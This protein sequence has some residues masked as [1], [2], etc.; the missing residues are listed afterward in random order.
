MALSDEAYDLPL[1][2]MAAC[3]GGTFTDAKTATDLVRIFS[4]I[5]ETIEESTVPF[6][7]DVK[8]IVEP[9]VTVVPGS[10]SG[11][12]TVTSLPD[13]TTQILWTNIDG[14]S[15]LSSSDPVKQF[16]YRA[17][18]SRGGQN[19]PVSVD[20]SQVSFTDKNG[21]IRDFI[22]T[23]IV[24]ANVNGSPNAVCKDASKDIDCTTDP[25][26]ACF[27][28]A[29]V[30]GGST[31]YVCTAGT[32]NSELEGFRL[33]PDDPACFGPGGH[34]VILDVN[35]TNGLDAQCTAK[36]FVRDPTG[37]GPPTPQTSPPTRSPTTPA[38]NVSPSAPTPPPTEPTDSFDAPALVP[39]VLPI[40]PAIAPAIAPFVNNV[41]PIPPF[42]VGDACE[43]N[44]CRF[45]SFLSGRYIH[46]NFF[47][48]FCFG[49]CTPI[50]G[51]FKV[52]YLGFGCGSCP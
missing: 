34:T 7:I 19:L 10:V 41:P 28:A 48:L 43:G 42:D 36:V 13:G 37:C 52:T 9:Y 3:T 39:F 2:D 44:Q 8:E 17:T 46:L 20:D 31:G 18:A 5:F 27:N 6:N 22:N 30:N 40:A 15:G 12:G 51:S 4:D 14:G 49:F 11:G 50:L 21:A 1:V 29:D 23:E 24:T 45:L 35:S 32:S 33:I 26:Q 47:G 38:P 16:T 25:D